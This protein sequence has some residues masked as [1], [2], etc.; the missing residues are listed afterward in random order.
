VQLQRRNRVL[1]Q[2][3]RSRA[4]DATVLKSFKSWVALSH[5][6]MQQR[7]AAARILSRLSQTSTRAAFIAW[8]S[9]A[10]STARS[11]KC[12]ALCM[13][14]FHSKCV[15]HAFHA[16]VSVADVKRNAKCTAERRGTKMD[17][18]LLRSAFAVCR[19]EVEFQRSL[20]ARA[21]RAAENS[22]RRKLYAILLEWRAVAFEQ[23]CHSHAIRFAFY[24]SIGQ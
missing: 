6:A 7:A 15:S 22:A 18:A 16:W 8:R 10:S 9:A 14:R 2:R 3:M 12:I 24:T 11:R 17:A 23:L 1:V 13:Q 5:S 19:E 21:E 4:R 20:C